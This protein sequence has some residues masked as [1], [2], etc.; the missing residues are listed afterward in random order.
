MGLSMIDVADLSTDVAKALSEIVEE[1]RRIAASWGKLRDADPSVPWEDFSFYKGNARWSA[2][3]SS[4]LA[5]LDPKSFAS[6]QEACDA[7]E[8]AVRTQDWDSDYDAPD[9]ARDGMLEAIDL[10]RAKVR[11]RPDPGADAREQERPIPLD[12]ALGECPLCGEDSFA[13]GK[14]ER[15]RAQPERVQLEL[16]CSGC[17]YVYVGWRRDWED[18]GLIPRS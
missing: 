3:A 11:P 7:A 12:K 5:A 8:N 16:R 2:D 1:A 13:T 9:A 15:S 6:V 18:M 4:V 14:T 17:R 10:A